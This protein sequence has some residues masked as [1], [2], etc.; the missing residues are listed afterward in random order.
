LLVLHVGTCSNPRR[1]RERSEERS[2]ME[3]TPNMPSMPGINYEEGRQAAALSNES[4]SVA[5]KAGAESEEDW[6]SQATGDPAFWIKE[7]EVG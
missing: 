5:G 3:H 1:V 7:P 6:L 2:V 4:P